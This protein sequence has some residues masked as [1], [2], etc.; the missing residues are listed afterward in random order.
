MQ[1]RPFLFPLVLLALATGPLA[2]AEPGLA[3]VASASLARL[4]ALRPELGLDAQSDFLLG[5]FETDTLGQVHA[6]VQQTFQGVP[7][8]G[9]QA[10]THQDAEG[11][12]L[13]LTDALCRN[14]HLSV[15]PGVTP[16]EV[17]ALVHADLAPLGPYRYPPT[18]ELKVFPL[19]ALVPRQ[20]V[21]GG[22]LGATSYIR[23]IRGATLV[24]HVHTQLEN[25]VRETAHTD[26]LV[27]AQTG[28][29]LKKWDDLHTSASSGIGH[30]QY[31]GTVR[32]DT[33]RSAKG[34]ELRDLTRG[35]GGRFK[36]NVVTNL[37]HETS[38][39]GAI[40]RNGSDTW[41]DGANY[42]GSD[43]ATTSATGQTA[44][45]DAAYGI[46]VA[47]DMYRN[48]FGRTGIDGKGTATYSRV[49]YSTSYDNA[50]WDDSCFCMTYG[51]GS[52]FKSLEALDVTG[53]ELSHGVCANSAKLLYQ[54]ESGGLNEANSDI[55]GTMAEFYAR[56]GGYEA[57]GATLPEEGGDWTMGEVLGPP[58]RYLYKPSKDGQSPDAWSSTL[59]DLDVH[60]SSG[61]MNRCFYFLS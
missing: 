12:P 28:A 5:S 25:G 6:H 37:D 4:Q 57:G 27:D 10:I 18:V 40:Y 32:L 60:F 58:L 1:Y 26:Y 8:W 52:D 48:V 9:G 61:P 2:G 29:I 14:L 50:F 53:H 3:A 34:F 41:G 7:V 36:N 56:G 38:G 16:S 33:N 30:T 59:G 43:T 11:R 24:F 31:S 44:A 17:L 19:V 35:K 39:D 47:W 55:L 20:G 15:L 23:E 22:A 42:I 13:P 51:D 54:G 46:Q 45:A 49:H 21:K